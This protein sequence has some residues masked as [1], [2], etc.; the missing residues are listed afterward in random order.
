MKHRINGCPINLRSL[1]DDQ[2]DRLIEGNSRRH[3]RVVYEQELLEGERARRAL[4]ANA[5]PESER[6]ALVASA[7]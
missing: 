6:S 4:G 7:A 5:S 1:A 2:L 3:G